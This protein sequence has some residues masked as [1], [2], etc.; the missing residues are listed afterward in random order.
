M[1]AV[2]SIDQRL[3]DGGA[4]WWRA[5]RSRYATMAQP[6]QWQLRAGRVL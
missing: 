3:L 6:D 4:V 2:H 1:A 5:P